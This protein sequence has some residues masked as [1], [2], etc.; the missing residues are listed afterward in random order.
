MNEYHYL[1]LGILIFLI[2]A[3]LAALAGLI[4]HI[5]G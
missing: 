5:G 2:L 3:V 1:Y 4:F